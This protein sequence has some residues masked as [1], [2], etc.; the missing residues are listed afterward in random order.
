MLWKQETFKSGIF[1]SNNIKSIPTNFSSTSDK[2]FKFSTKT[3]VNQLPSIKLK[4]M[5][6]LKLETDLLSLI[7]KVSLHT[8]NDLKWPPPENRF[9]QISQAIFCFMTYFFS[10]WFC[11]IIIISWNCNYYIIYFLIYFYFYFIF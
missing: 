9:W 1:M 11:I 4:T 6:D 3:S 5:D 8:L 10:Y 7:S 2:S